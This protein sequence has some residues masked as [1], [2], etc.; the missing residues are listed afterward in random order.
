MYI[1]FI[2][3]RFLI[4]QSHSLLHCSTQKYNFDLAL[5]KPYRHPPYNLQT[6]NYKCFPCISRV[7]N[8]SLSKRLRRP[9]VRPGI[10]IVGWCVTYI[11]R[12]TQT[13]VCVASI[14]L[15]FQCA[16]KISHF[17]QFFILLHREFNFGLFGVAVCQT[18]H[19]AAGY[20]S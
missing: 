10:H 12:E 8:R 4:G 3:F 1:C 13:S 7:P 19:R 16:N 15:C 2:C 14:V 20:Q 18:P 11:Y 17:V 6:T 5:R 9:S